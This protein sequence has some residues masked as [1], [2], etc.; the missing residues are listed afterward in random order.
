[1]NA[2]Q[3]ADKTQLNTRF[4]SQYLGEEVILAMQKAQI[5]NWIFMQDVDTSLPKI[6]QTAK[7]ANDIIYQRHQGK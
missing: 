7:D 4:A 1:M 6:L 5:L 2:K 3:L